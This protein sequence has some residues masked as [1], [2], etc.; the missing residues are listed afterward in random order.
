MNRRSF[1]KVLG[2]LSI[3][4]AITPV[5]LIQPTSRE[6]NLEFIKRVLRNSINSHDDLVEK[7]IFFKGHRIVFDHE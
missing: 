7:A 5:I 1:L 2:K 4:T 6:S 3:V